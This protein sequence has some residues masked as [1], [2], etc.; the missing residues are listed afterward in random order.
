VKDRTDV[1]SGYHWNSSEMEMASL[2]AAATANDVRAQFELGSI[3]STTGTEGSAIWLLK[4][5]EQG[6][7]HA[8]YE[9]A[10]HLR[11]NSRLKK[12]RDE[13]RAFALQ[14]Q[15]QGYPEAEGFDDFHQS[16][17][18]CAKLSFYSP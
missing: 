2:Q 7:A 11:H 15:L 10:T 16:G 3:L 14:S 12:E 17:A 8:Q 6:H 1:Y 9:H 4:A 5:C 18:L 13:A